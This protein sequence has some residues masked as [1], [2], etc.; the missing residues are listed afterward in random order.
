MQRLLFQ[1]ED[2]NQTQAQLSRV[3]PGHGTGLHDK[4]ANDDICDGRESLPWLVLSVFG[5]VIGGTLLLYG[6]LL[7]PHLIGL[8]LD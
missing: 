6:L 1:R 8:L 7:L 3:L 5:N 2:I 4:A